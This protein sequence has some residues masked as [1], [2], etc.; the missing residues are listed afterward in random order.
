MIIRKDIQFIINRLMIPL[1]GLIVLLF[2]LN[3]YY[4]KTPNDLITN[5]ITDLL[6]ILISSVFVAGVLNKNQKRIWE[7]TNNKIRKRINLLINFYI[8]TIRVWLNY[9]FDDVFPEEIDHEN[10]DLVNASIIYFAKNVLLQNF[11]ERSKGDVKWSE[12]FNGAFDSRIE[13]QGIKHVAKSLDEILTR[14]NDK[15]SPEL[16]SKLLDLDESLNFALL[17]YKTFPIFFRKPDFSDMYQNGW[18]DSTSRE[19]KKGIE[20]TI[21][22]YYIL[23]KE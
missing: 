19:L 22:I 12:I 14:Y 8:T 20:S 23:N 4:F 17:N 16:F 15:I 21:K 1:F 11:D 9:S 3:Y 7:E 5:L 2:G 10:I 18:R 6:T 13:Y